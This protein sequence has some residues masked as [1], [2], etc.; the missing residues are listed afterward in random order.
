MLN[1][2]CPARL[3]FGSNLTTIKVLPK[4][5]AYSISFLQFFESKYAWETH[6]IMNSQ[7][8][9]AS[10]IPSITW[11]WRPP[12]IRFQYF[13]FNIDHML[14]TVGR[15]VQ[16]PLIETSILHHP[17]K[18]R[19]PY[20]QEIYRE[21]WRSLFYIPNCNLSLI[22]PFSVFKVRIKLR[23]KRMAFIENKMKTKE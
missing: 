16:W 12:L 9:T 7:F 11:P 20:Q 8:S 22:L 5:S 21:H 4:S 19:I 6:T 15:S 10:A 14:W 23:A 13:P 1:D 3:R 17:S 2:P 18:H